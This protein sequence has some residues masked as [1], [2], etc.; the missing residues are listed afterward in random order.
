MTP[1]SANS[2]AVTDV[3][4]RRKSLLNAVV[5]RTVC[6]PSIGANRLD[7]N[8]GH[9]VRVMR[10]A[11]CPPGHRPDQAFRL[12]TRPGPT[13]STG[14]PQIERAKAVCRA[15]DVVA[16]CLEWALE[17]NQTA[18]VWGGMDEDER[19]ALRRSRERRRRIVS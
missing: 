15:C 4:G 6:D 16:Q 10:Y 8:F 2:T 1:S 11:C 14:G 13:T 3:S 18:G 12:S 5:A 7:P 19:R 9:A 17:T